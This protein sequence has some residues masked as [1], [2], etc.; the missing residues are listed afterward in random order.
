MRSPLSHQ[1]VC[2]YVDP[3]SDAYV[4]EL[5]VTSSGKD[6]IPESKTRSFDLGR[7][8]TMGRLGPSREVKS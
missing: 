6:T 3:S 2:N 7:R 5:C 1:H 4:S 8:L